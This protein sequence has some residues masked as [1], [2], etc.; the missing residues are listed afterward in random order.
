MDNRENQHPDQEN[1]SGDVGQVELAEFLEKKAFLE[2]IITKWKEGETP[3]PQLLED[4]KAALEQLT[5][6]AQKVIAEHDEV[7][8][9][10]MYHD[11]REKAEQ[12]EPLM[13]Q[14]ARWLA[15]AEG[16]LGSKGEEPEDE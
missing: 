7:F 16:L 5:S 3:V 11:L 1:N 2:E 6:L 13:I 14:Y 10:V 4:V 8:K 15:S 9:E 12:T